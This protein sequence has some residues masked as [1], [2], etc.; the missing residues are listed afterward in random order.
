MKVCNICSNRND[1]APGDIER[2]YVI[3]KYCGL[4]VPL[5]EADKLEEEL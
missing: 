1:I 5:S 4:Y 3:C 2:G